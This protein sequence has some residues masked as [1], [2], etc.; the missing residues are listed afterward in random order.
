MQTLFSFY[1]NSKH[2]L[3]YF[4]KKAR[5]Q[6][7]KTIAGLYVEGSQALAGPLVAAVCVLPMRFSLKDIKPT[8]KL[9]HQITSY[10]DLLYAIE[11]I[12]PEHIQKRGLFPSITQSMETVLSELSCKPD[13]ILIN[14]SYSPFPLSISQTIL[15]GDTLSLSI[16]SAAVLAKTTRDA[17][18][19]G[20]D[21]AWPEYSFAQNKGLAT[22]QHKS[23]LKTLGPSPIHIKQNL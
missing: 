11:V 5:A 2:D 13:L 23:L 9:Y 10:P 21:Q 8:S 19:D 22:F 14:G 18:M 17:I 15:Q 6:G 3:L 7:H 12:E 1:E 4:E 20:Y 16:A